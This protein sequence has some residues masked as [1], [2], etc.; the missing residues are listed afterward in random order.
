MTIND[1][2]YYGT[3][4]G[5]YVNYQGDAIALVQNATDLSLQLDFNF[6]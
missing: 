4:G 2:T 1:G 6:V 3:L 5:V